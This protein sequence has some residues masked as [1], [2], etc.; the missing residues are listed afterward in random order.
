[1]AAVR[2]N[3]PYHTVIKAHYDDPNCSLRFCDLV[4]N[5]MER[6]IGAQQ[7]GR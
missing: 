3:Y 4:Y 2:K 5:P 6:P 7:S 1:M